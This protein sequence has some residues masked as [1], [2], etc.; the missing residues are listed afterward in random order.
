MDVVIITVDI[1]NLTSGQSRYAFN[2][3]M[4]LRLAGNSVGMVSLSSSDKATRA[5]EEANV[6][7]SSLHTNTRGLP[8]RVST[9]ISGGVVANR[10]GGLARR[11][12]KPDWYIVTGDDCI[13][14]GR[15][16]SGAARAYVTHGDP[17]LLYTNR[18]LYNGLGVG[19]AALS[20]TM[21]L[22]IVQRSAQVLYY[23]LLLA[24]SQ[25]T[26][27]I[28]SY[29]YGVPF[30]RVLSPPVDTQ[31]FAPTN[32]H[33][34]PGY[35]LTMLRNN[36]EQNIHLIERV[37]QRLP[38]VVVGEASPAN[39][40]LAGASISDPEL[41]TLYG[42]ARFLIFPTV[43]EMLG[44]PVLE[45]LAC[46]TPVLCFDSGGPSELVQ[47]G[48]NGWLAVDERHF[49]SR[50]VEAYRAGT[51]VE[52][53]KRARQ[54]VMKYSLDAVGHEFSAILEKKLMSTLSK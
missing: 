41:V 39:C 46:G 38:V 4:A 33:P 54:S 26:R 43:S 45:S 21:A 9:M 6:P 52:I 34:E 49:V 10:L 51:S 25:T 37:A 48:Y 23:D 28:M 5:L 7:V 20:T 3:A 18:E 27:T 12:P 31:F 53:R 22:R 17:A 15:Q 32:E 36:R 1:G 50:A 11:L 14:V 2:L 13:G 44:L 16:L 19:L 47:D 29:L 42:K 8:F 35:V 24:N 40:R 30:E